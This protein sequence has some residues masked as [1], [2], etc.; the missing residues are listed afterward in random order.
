MKF[1]WQ[2]N[3]VKYNLITRSTYT[4]YLKSSSKLQKS[5]HYTCVYLQCYLHEALTNPPISIFIFS[6]VL[7]KYGRISS[8]FDDVI[9]RAHSIQ[10]KVSPHCKQYRQRN[11]LLQHIN[12]GDLLRST[13]M[14]STQFKN[15]CKRALP[16][17]PRGSQVLTHLCIYV[18]MSVLYISVHERIVS[19]HEH[20][21][22]MC[23]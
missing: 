13:R 23:T 14:K 22:C 2:T 12:T 16:R 17:I 18:Y 5:V 15:A 19:V 8:T 9:Y 4:A 6:R 20:I 3:D 11:R 10:S 21:I 7:Y 1:V